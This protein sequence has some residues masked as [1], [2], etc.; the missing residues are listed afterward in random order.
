MIA[1]YTVENIE[2]D[3]WGRPWAVLYNIK[4]G[5]SR[6]NIEI[7]KRCYKGLNKGDIIRAIFDDKQIKKFMG[8][9]DKGKNIY[10]NTGKTRRWITKYERI[11]K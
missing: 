4:C 6:D 7:N 10:K 8:K 5:V 1:K 2:V 11:E 3:K 9:D